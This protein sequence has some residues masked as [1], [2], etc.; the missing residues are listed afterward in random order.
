MVKSLIEAGAVVDY[1]H[2]KIGS[3]LSIAVLKDDRETAEALLAS[4]ASIDLPSP[5]GARPLHYAAYSGNVA[6]TKWLVSSKSDVRLPNLQGGTPLRSAAEQ[7][8]AEIVAL[9]LEAGASASSLDAF[10]KH[11]IDYA[12]EAGHDH[13][14]DLLE[15]DKSLA[16]QMP[17]PWPTTVSLV[18]TLPARSDASLQGLRHSIDQGYG[19]A[20]ETG[21]SSIEAPSVIALIQSIAPDHKIFGA[22]N[23]S[24][25][26]RLPARDVD[27]ML[28][29][30]KESGE[31]TERAHK[32]VLRPSVE[33]VDLVAHIAEYPY[34]LDAWSRA[35]AATAEQLAPSDLTNIL[36]VSVFPPDGPSYIEPWDWYFRVQVAAALI[37]SHLGESPWVDSPSRHA[38]EAVLDGPADWTNTAAIIALLDVARRD[39]VARP[40][41]LETLLRTARRPVTPPVYQHAIMPA[42]L[43]I[44]EF[45]DVS[46]EVSDEMT[47]LIK[48]E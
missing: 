8:H 21:T 2:P 22:L 25:D 4:G 35:A 47:S 32:A 16:A 36:A 28:W 33:F 45:G 34:Q 39:E 15:A 23:D 44:L 11:P 43:A 29:S 37:A 46:S 3:P 41:V 9:L 12:R 26:P 1:S 38:L 48:G 6:L 14:V 7:G 31:L 18:S 24:P 20:G 30:Y 17:E 40:L 27:F 42:A 13:V 10:D 5:G 19:T